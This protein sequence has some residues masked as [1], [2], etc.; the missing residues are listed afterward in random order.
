[1]HHDS[2]HDKNID[3]A[4]PK[5]GSPA[6]GSELCIERAAVPADSVGIYSEEHERANSADRPSPSSG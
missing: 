1:M 4:G 3:G 2:K 5:A 6:N